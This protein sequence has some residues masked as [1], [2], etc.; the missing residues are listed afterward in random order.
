MWKGTGSIYEVGRVNGGR[1]CWRVGTRRE[2]RG[3][4]RDL[5]RGIERN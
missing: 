1:D 4:D 5:K 2:G 3:G